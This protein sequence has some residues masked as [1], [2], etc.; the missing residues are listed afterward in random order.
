MK[1]I[2]A[3]NHEEAIR[4][5]VEDIYSEQERRPCKKCGKPWYM[6]PYCNGEPCVFED[7]AKLNQV[8]GEKG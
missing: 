5:L 2:K 6:H 8:T 1:I 7:A 4:F 3:N